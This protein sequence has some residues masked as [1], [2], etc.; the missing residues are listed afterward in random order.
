MTVCHSSTHVAAV[1]L[2]GK[3]G[4]V[5]RL[6]SMQSIHSA[7]RQQTVDRPDFQTGPGFTL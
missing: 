7:H 3:R 5:A 6:K 1:H 2:G 4:R